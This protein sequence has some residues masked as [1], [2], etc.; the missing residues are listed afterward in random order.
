M[1]RQ[2]DISVF[3]ILEGIKAPFLGIR[4]QINIFKPEAVELN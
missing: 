3:Q 4:I 1:T 2:Y